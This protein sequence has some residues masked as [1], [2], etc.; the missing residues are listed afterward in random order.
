MFNPELNRNQENQSKILMPS[1]IRKITDKRERAMAA[2][3]SLQ[4]GIN[5]MGL[6]HDEI[7][8]ILEAMLKGHD[9]RTF[10]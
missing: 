8:E 10:N 7:D 2:T 9:T 3:A 5:A 6:S 1:D 4:E